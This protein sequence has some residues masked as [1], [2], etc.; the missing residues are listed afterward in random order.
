MKTGYF[1]FDPLGFSKSPEAA[2]KLAVNELKVSVFALYMTFHSLYLLL[3]LFCNF[4]FY[5]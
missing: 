3:T 5:P 2:K 1:A 4:D